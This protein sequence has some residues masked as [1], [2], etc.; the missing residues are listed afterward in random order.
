MTKNEIFALDAEYVDFA[1]MEALLAACDYENELAAIEV[2]QA[3]MQQAALAYENRFWWR[4]DM[5][6]AA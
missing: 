4:D 5:E 2:E 6:V 3:A 1:E